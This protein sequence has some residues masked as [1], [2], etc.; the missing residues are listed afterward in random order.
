MALSESQA[1]VLH[2]LADPNPTEALRLSAI[3]ARV[4]FRAEA[5]TRDAL[6]ALTFRGLAQRSLR[7]PAEWRITQTGRAVVSRPAY[8]RTELPDTCR[9]GKE[10]E[11]QECT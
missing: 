8:R 10:I 3:H 4:P 1:A 9:D 5:T 6:K 7:T 2:V 11:T